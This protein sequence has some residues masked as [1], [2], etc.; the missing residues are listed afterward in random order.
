MIALYARQSVDR[1]ESISIESQLEFCRYE[2]RGEPYKTYV[3]R[4]YSGKSTVRPAFTELMQD[5]EQGALHKVIVYKLDRI[6]RSILDFANMMERFGDHNVEFVSATEKFDTSSP[7]GRAML[8][9]CIV[10]AQLERETIQKRV[11][12]AYFARS[13]RGFYMGG[14]RPYGYQLQETS[15]GEKKTRMYVPVAEEATQICRIY[16]LY[17]R[18]DCSYTTIETLFRRQGITKAGKPWVRSRLSDIV[19]NPIYV[20]ADERIYD[21]YQA[22][23][24]QIINPREDFIGVCGCYRYHY[25]AGHE[26]LV[27]APHQGL[28][29]ADV[30]LQCRYKTEKYKNSR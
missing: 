9:I 13:Q 21:Y 19:R 17:A 28:V 10:F 15:I 29:T 4:G 8:H 22:R 30:W 3:D 26:T 18:E 27:L 16:T 20:R 11:A 7:M 23:G 5:V 1:A 6:S 2:A 14:R 25:G 24:A 12:D